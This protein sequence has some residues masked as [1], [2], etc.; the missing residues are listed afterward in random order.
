MGR[1]IQESAGEY[2][3]NGAVTEAQI[4]KLA[5]RISK[6]KL[7]TG[8]A[9][10]TPQLVKT[11]I[12]Q[13]LI[14]EPHEVFGVVFLDN[15]HRVI[16]TKEMFFGTIDSASVYPR[17]VVKESLE[18]NAAAVI[19]Y[20]NHPSGVSE[21]SRGDRLITDKLKHALSFVD[22]KVLDHFIV[23]ETVSS[24]AERGWL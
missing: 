3:I 7:T 14:N 8:D 15:K 9:M 16:D 1:F 20:H 12:Q 19:F 5:L 24:F 22:I 4:I 2:T 23:G 10:T 13:K 11:Y 6:S 17:V 21:A 18:K